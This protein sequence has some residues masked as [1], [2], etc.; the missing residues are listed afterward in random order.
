MEGKASDNYIK[1]SS[2][3]FN[4]LITILK[5]SSNSKEIIDKDGLFNYLES[6]VPKILRDSYTLDKKIDSLIKVFKEFNTN[7]IIKDEKRFTEYLYYLYYPL[8]EYI[9]YH[10]KI[11]QNKPLVFGIFGHQGTG[12]TT[13]SNILQELFKCLY[14][15]QVSFISIDDLY[16]TFSELENLKKEEKEYKYRGPPGTHDINLGVDLLTRFKN[17]EINYLLPRYDKS[18]NNGLGDRSESLSERVEKPQDII[19]FEGW[20]LGVNPVTEDEIEDY[21]NKE[22]SSKFINL[23]LINKMNDKLNDYKKLWNFI[24]IMI[25]LRPEQY[26]LS[27]KWRIQAEEEMIQRTGK[28]LNNEA[29]NKFIDFFWECLPPY[30]FFEGKNNLKAD[31]EIILD[32]ERNFRFKN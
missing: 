5:H 19:I 21:K 9:H 24:D 25:I 4:Q 27:R 2:D 20:F 18:M 8:V 3:K 12:K 13:L 17:S 28:G 6:F 15:Y 14:D 30:L 26:E 11:N 29:I 32:E 23:N 31:F 10:K 16:K 22:I 7:K 1:I